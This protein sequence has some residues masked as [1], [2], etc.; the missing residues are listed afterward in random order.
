MIIIL[1]ILWLLG[2]I[3]FVKLAQWTIYEFNNPIDIDDYEKPINN[4][5]N[6]H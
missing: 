5:K 3:S 1:Y 4:S 2:F 6:Y